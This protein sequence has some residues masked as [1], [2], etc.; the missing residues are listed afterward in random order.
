MEEQIFLTD[1]LYKEDGSLELWKKFKGKITIDKVILLRSIFDNNNL[2]E[3]STII[4]EL[5]NNQLLTDNIF[6]CLRALAFPA[7]DYYKNIKT[8]EEIFTKT[9]IVHKDELLEKL[10]EYAL[11]KIPHASIPDH[12]F[13]SY[14]SLIK[15]SCFIPGKG[16]DVKKVYMHLD[17]LAIFIQVDE[18]KFLW[19]K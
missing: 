17:L 5:N 10:F 18:E 1:S 7:E 9:Q 3:L 15:N 16:I 19:T 2:K 6:P 8:L 13:T 11:D 12:Q 4:I 14:V